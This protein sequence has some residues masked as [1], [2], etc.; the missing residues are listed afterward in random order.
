MVVGHCNQWNLNIS[1]YFKG[2]PL[3]TGHV[4]HQK[5]SSK[6]L[7]MTSDGH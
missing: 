5:K 6:Q 4:S 2:H 7:T 1:G 3:L